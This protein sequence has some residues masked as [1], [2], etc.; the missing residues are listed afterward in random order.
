MGGVGL[1]GHDCAPHGA[2]GE[3][4]SSVHELLTHH[5]CTCTSTTS[6]CQ[7]RLDI[8]VHRENHKVDSDDC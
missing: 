6:F 7:H 8:E 4:L 1:I 3:D 2:C 5:R